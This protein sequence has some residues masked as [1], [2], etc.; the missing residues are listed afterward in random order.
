[1]IVG[2][3]F[4]V[5][6]A[7]GLIAVA[8]C[9]ATVTSV[10]SWPYL[11]AEDGALSSG[12]VVK[13]DPTASGGRYI[14]VQSGSAPDDA[15][16]GPSRATYEL[17]ITKTGTYFIWGRIRSPSTSANRFWVKVDDGSW[18]LWRITVGDIWFWDRF[19]D[20]MDYDTPLTFQ[21]SAGTH[22]LLLA[23]S[24]DGVDLDRLYYTTGPETPPGNT[25]PCDPPN[26]IELAG[27]CHPSCGSQGGNDC[28]VTE[29]MGQ[30]TLPAYDC[31][32]CCVVP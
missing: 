31:D 12:F 32:V 16:P 20:D 28:G 17:P 9:E 23:N 26:S 7:S 30:P 29:C 21:L 24:V 8:G 1:M 11:E 14:E 10:G 5:A 19:H 27:V 2:R 15:A 18:Y 3:L 22:Q 6:V 25:T 13:D 4:A